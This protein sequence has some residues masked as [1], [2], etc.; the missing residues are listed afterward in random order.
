MR[1]RFQN[2]VIWCLAAPGRIA[3]LVN[4]L[5]S[6]LVLA[7][8]AVH[9]MDERRQHLS[10]L[11]AGV[12]SMAQTQAALIAGQIQQYQALMSQLEIRLRVT[13][14]LGEGQGQRFHDPRNQNRA[15]AAMQDLL[16][17][18]QNLLPG[19]RDL[20][21]V[22]DDEHFASASDVLDGH[23]HLSRY[24]ADFGFYRVLHGGPM[25]RAYQGRAV[26]RCPPPGTLIFQRA[27]VTQDPATALELWMLV[28]PDTLQAFLQRNRSA[29]PPGS[30]FRVLG[31]DGS[32]LAEGSVG[33]ADPQGISFAQAPAAPGVD[34]TAATWTDSANGTQVAAASAAVPLGDLRVDIAYPLE[35]SLNALWWPYARQWGWA[36]AAFLVLWWLGLWVVV[37]LV[38]NHRAALADNEKRFDLS[39][40]FARLG[41]WEW[42]ARRGDVHWSHRVGAM[43]GLK[44]APAHVMLQ[45]YMDRVVEDDRPPMVEAM[46]RCLKT[47]EQFLVAHR[48][49]W[50]DGSTHWLQVVGNVQRNPARK[51]VKVLGILEDITARKQAEF[52]LVESQSRMAGVLDTAMDAIISIDDQFHIILFNR[53]AEAMFARTAAEM[54]GHTLDALI[55]ESLRNLH[56]AHVRDYAAHGGTSRAMGVARR[57]VALRASGEEFPIEAS[58]SRVKVA[59]RNVFTVIVRDITDRARAFEALQRSEQFLRQAQMA[60]RIGVFSLDLAS[61]TWSGSEALDALFGITAHH[62]H[63]LQVW[64]QLMVEDALPQ[65][66]DGLQHISPEQPNVKTEFQIIRPSDGQRRWMHVQ[67]VVQFTATGAASGVFGTVQDI[68][69]RRE[70][71]DQL[72]ELNETLEARVAERTQALRVALAHAEEA[73]RI[74]GEFLARMSHEIRTPMNAMLGLT[75]L[76]LKTDLSERQRQL[77]SKVQTAGEHLLRIIN[78]ILDFSKIDAGKL[79]LELAPFR[80]ERTL[81]N[82]IQLCEGRARDKG[83]D[84]ALQVAPDVP[85][86]VVGDSLRLEQVLINYIHNA[87]KFTPAG[88]V[89]VAVSVLT[90]TAKDACM[91]RFEVSDTGIGMTDA[92]M[93]RLFESFEQADTSTTR[94]FGGTGLGLAICRQLARMMGGDVG[95][96][97]QPGEGSR[98]W[99]TARLQFPDPDDVFQSVLPSEVASGALLAGKRVLVVDDNDLNLDVA[100]GVLEGVDAQVSLAMNGQQALDR[101]GEQAFDIVLMDMHMPVMDGIEAVQRMREVPAWT[102]IP[103]IAMTANARQED[104]QRCLDAGMNDVV[105]KPFDPSELFAKIETLLQVAGG[106]ALPLR[107]ASATSSQN[108]RL[109]DPAQLPQW[110]AAALSRVVGDNPQVH[111]RL[112]GKFQQGLREFLQALG[113]PEALQNWVALGDHAH[114]VKSS[115]RTVGAMQAGAL[116]EQMEKAGRANDRATCLALSGPLREALLTVDN[117]LQELLLPSPDGPGAAPMG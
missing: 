76:A 55:P 9:L 28:S 67:G 93:A 41:V 23:E 111:A 102:Q 53:A 116:L 40:D 33:A 101:L 61:Q 85:E 113:E 100:Q 27:L 21:L 43:I 115:A 34:R 91:L 97:S 83:L 86:L 2:V 37:A 57:L 4:L 26:G 15:D 29:L 98:F 80:L 58:I 62:P 82:V 47:G 22:A 73:K 71:Q 96:S 14:T 16:R 54:M 1:Q 88:R 81:R 56:R 50:P 69:E 19:T 87:I 78:D 75:F 117:R 52:A 84:L 64:R 109:Q 107:Q 106:G 3:W 90:S 63:T 92:Q 42:D 20:L 25:V 36:S 89:D 17:Q 32:A 8:I 35:A 114:K 39:L 66:M 38:K 59:G 104:H 77:L 60:G 31:A 68:T 110:D 12:S 18:F 51:S 79:D 99:F 46:E 6:A 24:C 70:A 5:V 105:V 95:V 30:I 44:D 74:R 49:V 13:Q 11:Q 65:I 48:V 112:L 7:A 103:V 10:A 45:D 94:R 72:R 108:A